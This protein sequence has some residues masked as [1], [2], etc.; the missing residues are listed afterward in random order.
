MDSVELAL[1]WHGKR[2][3]P[4]SPLGGASKSGAPVGP[5]PWPRWLGG[6][7]STTTT[8]LAGFGGNEDFAKLR[9]AWVSEVRGTGL[10]A[11]AP[12][13]SATHRVG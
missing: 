10:A 3:F 8:W 7:T 6:E 2:A 1:K 4:T 13:A 9:L 5:L 12:R 11:A